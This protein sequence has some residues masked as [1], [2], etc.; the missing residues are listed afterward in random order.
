MLDG[1]KSEFM[2]S[3]MS[4]ADVGQITWCSKKPAD[5]S[6]CYQLDIK[7]V[8]GYRDVLQSL[9]TGQKA[10]FG[11][12]LPDST[13]FILTLQLVWMIVTIAL[14]LA[15]HFIPSILEIYGLFALTSFITER[16]I[17]LFTAPAW[18]QHVIYTTSRPFTPGEDDGTRY[19]WKRIL[20]VI[21]YILTLSWPI[22]MIVYGVKGPSKDT[23]LTAMFCLSAG[24][25]HVSGI[26]WLAVANWCAEHR[27]SSVRWLKWLPNVIGYL[28][29]VL[30][31]I[32]I[33]GLGVWQAYY[34]QREIFLMPSK[35]WDIP[36][37]TG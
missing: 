18:E 16:L 25:T 7:D 2:R 15:H 6:G 3:S 17:T 33:I 27:K 1:T 34:G 35:N 31:R 9:P 14:R 8:D 30:S 4:F 32:M 29:I 11:I 28:S 37:L 24:G 10:M 5:D 23:S 12:A 20:A 21:P 13:T 26:V 19:T 22:Y 36:H